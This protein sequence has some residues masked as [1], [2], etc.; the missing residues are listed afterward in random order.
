MLQFSN[1]MLIRTVLMMLAQLSTLTSS[2]ANRVRNKAETQ[3]ERA[4]RGN[5]AAKRIA[6][7]NGSNTNTGADH[8]T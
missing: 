2:A 3:A 5:T 1:N 8:G 7:G 6:A 4:S